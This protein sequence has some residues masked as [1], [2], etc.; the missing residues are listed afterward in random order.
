[1]NQTLSGPFMAR[2]AGLV[3]E[4]AW[5]PKGRELETVL[6]DCDLLDRCF[7]AFRRH[8]HQFSDL[9]VDKMRRPVTSDN[10]KL[11][12]GRTINQVI[13]MVVRS[14]AKRY[15]RM[16][17]DPTGSRA[18]ARQP[19]PGWGGMLAWMMGRPARP[20]RRARTPADQLYGAIR[21]YLL[22][23]WQAPFIP[24]YARMTPAEVRELG[25]RLLDFREPEELA[26]WIDGGETA[27]RVPQ[28][29]AEDIPEVEAWP[30][31]EAAV[32]A[33]P[34]AGLAALPSAPLV[35]D[36]RA[37]I[38]DVLSADGRSLRVE[39]VVPVLVRPDVRA[40]LGDPGRDEL[41]RAVRALALTGPAT[42]RHLVVEFG[43][44]TD[45]MAALLGQAALWLP[46]PVY[47][48]MFGRKGDMLLL[49][50]LIRKAR[51]SGIDAQSGPAS[52]AAFMLGLLARVK[53]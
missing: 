43:L 6:R 50:A 27:R 42:V 35:R 34:A 29:L 51:A 24:Q 16:R 53:G 41:R 30:E 21:R 17:L 37:S 2:M 33:E 13:A 14:A 49:A 44:D 52:L 36:R 12:C 25:A 20:A 15:F 40:A 19:E 31:P 10:A 5:A 32:D 45:Q 4:L 3:P 11:A 23:D 18:L 28:P 39:S 48:R 46:A 7:V 47:E 38:A 9:L 1:L 26:R 22:H 8:R